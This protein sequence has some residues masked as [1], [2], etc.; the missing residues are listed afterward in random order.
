TEVTLRLERWVNMASQG[1]YSADAHIHANYT[2]SAPHRQ[3]ITPEDVRLQTLGEDL[4]NANLMVANSGSG[5]LHDENRFEGKPHRLSLP[6]YVMYWNEEMRN[7][8]IYGHMS[9]FNLKSLVHPL[10]T[11]FRDTPHWED[12]PPNYAQAKGARDQGGAVTYVHPGYAPKLSGASARELPVDLALGE[13]DAIDVISNNPEEVA[14]EL[15]HRLLNCGFRLSI[16]AGTD[17]FT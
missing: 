13:I 6:A 17:A 5:F 7:S 1:W 3:V 4:N 9:F 11:G 16:S 15:W 12:Y 10:Y 14:M 8:G 2:S